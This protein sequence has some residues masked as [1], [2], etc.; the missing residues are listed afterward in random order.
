[1]KSI[2][3]I[4]ILLL[5]LIVSVNSCSTV[6]ITER[7]RVNIVDDQDILPASFA[8]YDEFLKENKL[9]TDAARANEIKTVGSNIANAVDRFMRANG[10]T[11]EADNYQWEFN[12]V[13]DE[14]M[15]AW[16]LPGGKVVFYTG[17]L[18][19][20]Q[21]TD[22]IAAVMGHEIAHAFAKH[23]QERMTSS[24]GQQLG[25]MAVA[26]GTSGQSSDTQYLWNSIYGISSQ[27]GML[28]YSRT[29]ET[30]ADKLGMVFMTMAGYDPEEAIRLWQRMKEQ[31]EGSAPPEFMSTHPSN[32]TRI[33]NLKKYLPIARMNAREFGVQSSE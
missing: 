5:L 22:G 6:P 30:E 19:V 2:L 7:K 8:Q 11:E 17:I 1:M 25:G 12:L 13:E 3:D 21:N 31:S 10:M 24:Y 15:N 28:A 20:C 29:H 27:V 9:S 26:I 16:C 14:Q 32:D 18:P 33:E 23:G 4:R